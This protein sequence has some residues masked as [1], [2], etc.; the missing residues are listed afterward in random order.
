MPRKLIDACL[1]R[2]TEIQKANVWGKVHVKTSIRIFHNIMDS[3]WTNG[4]AIGSVAAPESPSQDNRTSHHSRHCEHQKSL[5]KRWPMATLCSKHKNDPSKGQIGREQHPRRRKTITHGT[6]SGILR[7][8]LCAPGRIYRPEFLKLNF[9]MTARHYPSPGQWSMCGSLC[10]DE[11]V[12]P[13]A[14]SWRSLMLDRFKL[15]YLL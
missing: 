12:T 4:V 14:C 11:S 10:P 5:R 6:N 9:T 1:V 7:A 15:V 3:E 13:N 2:R 8:M